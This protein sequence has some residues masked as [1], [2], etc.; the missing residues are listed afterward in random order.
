MGEK[1]C[2]CGKVLCVSGGGCTKENMSGREVVQECVGLR[3]RDVQVSVS[4]G[5]EGVQVRVGEG[6]K[7]VGG[8]EREGVQRER[9]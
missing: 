5:G 4:G 2:V 3:E 8:R 9:A 6:V 7:C 1:V